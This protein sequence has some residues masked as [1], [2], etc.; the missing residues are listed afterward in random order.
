M[1]PKAY[2][3]IRFSTPDQLNG[4]SLRRQLDLSKRYAAQ[5]GLVLDENLNL[6]DLGLSAYHGEHREGALGRFLELVKGSRISEGSVLLVESLD[7][8]SR[9]VK[10]GVTPTLFTPRAPSQA[11]QQLCSV[12]SPLQP[13]CLPRHCQECRCDPS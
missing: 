4:D 12:S 13:V 9:E 6:Q 5:H 11:F 7:R 2:S 8:L 3:Y 10:R 1:T